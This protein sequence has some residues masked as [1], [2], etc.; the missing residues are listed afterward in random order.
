P[1]GKPGGPV[2]KPGGPAKHV[3]SF[4]ARTG[5]PVGKPGGPVGKPGGPAKQC[6]RFAQRC[7]AGDT[8]VALVALANMLRPFRPKTSCPSW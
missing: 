5:I 1:V 2:G 8:I 4:A 7:Y 6:C 3:G